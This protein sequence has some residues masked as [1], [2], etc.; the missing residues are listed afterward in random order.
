MCGIVG[1]TG[2][3]NAENIV[4]DGLKILEYRGYDSAG[5]AMC[6]NGTL[7][8]FKTA[9]G[10]AQLLP[11]LPEAVSH[12]AIGHTRWATHGKP[13]AQNS[14]PHLSFDKRIAIVHNGVIEN[15]EELRADLQKRGITFQS[16]TDSEIIAHMLALENLDDMPRA[17]ENVGK[18][19]QGANTFIAMKSGDNAIYARKFGASLAVGFGENEN[20]VASDTLAI[21][22]HTRNIAVLND[23]EC[24]VVKP[25]EIKFFKNGK[26]IRKKAK[27]IQRTPP[28]ECSC[29]MRAEIDEISSA[30]KNTYA[31][32]MS[33]QPAINMLA[34]AKK[35]IIIGCGT[36]YHAGLYAKEVIERLKNI[37]CECIVASEADGLRFVNKD[38][39]AIAISQ[40]GETADTLFALEQCKQNGAKTLAITNVE[41]SSLALSADKTV[42]LNAGAEV[43]VAATK[44]YNCQL[45][46]LYLLTKYAIKEAFSVDDLNALCTAVQQA[47]QLSLYEEK[48]KNSNMF[49][50]GKGIDNM[51]AQEGALKFKEITYKMTDAYSTGE[52]K[53]GAIA[54]IDDKS[55]VVALA[56]TANDK[57]LEATVSELRSRGAYCISVSPYRY[58]CA[59][60]AF[61]LP[62]LTDELLY[63]ILSII[64]LQNLAL[65]SSLCLGLNP[66]KPRNLAKSVTVI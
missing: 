30:L 65:T 1:Y 23:G 42:L 64:P 32:V 55:C 22:K 6:L 5:I 16:Q 41:G 11:L 52:L 28:K 53:H 15:C 59:D 56:S 17:L 40:S 20:F 48:I 18:S 31:S 4:V 27:K 2:Y 37:P 26:Q 38:C 49:F 13:C 12:T 47:M 9:G 14:H 35:V 29:H 24:A 36:A 66:D 7:A 58:N 34:R 57:R 51:T 45:F 43:A 46:A 19:L 50:I 61:V 44:S 62:H 10:V 54:L 8:I 39:L 3:Q 60:K 21:S 63:P 33:N 25:N